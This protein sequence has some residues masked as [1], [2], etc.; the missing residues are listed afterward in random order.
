MKEYRISILQLPVWFFTS[1]GCSVEC[2]QCLPERG[3]LCGRACC[4]L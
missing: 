4:W 2:F 1:C 3:S